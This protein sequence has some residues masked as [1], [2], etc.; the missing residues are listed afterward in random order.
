MLRKADIR[1]A[2]EDGIEL[3]AWPFVMRMPSGFDLF[4][5]NLLHDLQRL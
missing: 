1:F 3:S 5:D 2:V 4:A